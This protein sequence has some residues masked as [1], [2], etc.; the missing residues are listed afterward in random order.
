[1][2]IKR[3][4]FSSQLLNGKNFFYKN[5]HN[6]I[7]FI[8]ILCIVNICLLCCKVESVSTLISKL[9]SFKTVQRKWIKRWW[10]IP[11]NRVL[12]VNSYANNI[13]FLVQSCSFQQMHPLSLFNTSYTYTQLCYLFQPLHKSQFRLS[14]L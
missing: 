12:R 5:Q 8:S 10:R 4:V 13:R 6:I 2:Y 1:M 14:T 9:S 3:I 7:L 11:K